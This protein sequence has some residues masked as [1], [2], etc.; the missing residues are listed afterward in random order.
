QIHACERIAGD[1]P[2]TAM[3]V[4]ELAPEDTVEDPRRDRSAKIAVQ[5]RHRPGLD[6]PA[7]ARAHHELEAFVE[8]LDERRQPP[9]VVR[10]IGVSHEDVASPY[11][12]QG[13][14]VGPA[15]TA[16]RSLQDSGAVLEGDLCGAIL[17]AVDDEDLSGDPCLSKALL[18]PV[19]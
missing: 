16:F 7:P 13:V 4:R 10:A 12:G 3:D 18:A 2:H 8:A 19:D 11:V 14:D 6:R 1:A 17:R 15:E 5:R 9:E